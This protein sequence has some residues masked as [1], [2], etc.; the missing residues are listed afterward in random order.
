MKTLRERNQ[1]SCGRSVL[2]ALLAV[3]AS[4]ASAQAPREAIVTREAQDLYRAGV[5]NPY[6]LKTVNCREQIFG[7][8]VTFRW[9]VGTKGGVMIRRGATDK[10]CY[11]EKVFRE[12]DVRTMQPIT[13]F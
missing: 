8:R 9:N 11:I 2:A 13:G 1:R 7:D 10:V 6:Y 12:V 4:A 5:T 3:F